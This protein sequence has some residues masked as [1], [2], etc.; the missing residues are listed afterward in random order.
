MLR[1]STLLQQSELGLRLVQAGPHDPEVSWATITELTDLGSYLDGGEIIMTTG[2]ALTSDDPRWRDFVS[3]LSRAQVAAIGFG[4]GVSHEHIPGPL[5]RAASDYRLALF[6]VP[7][8][9]PFIAVSKAV[10]GLLRADELRGAQAALRTQ[11]RILDSVGGE[12]DPSEVLASIA[13]VTGRQLQLAEATNVIASTAG[14]AAA[15]QHGPLDTVPLDAEGT[16]MLAIAAGPP[17]T[18]EGRSV[19]TAGAM[20]LSLSLRSAS[21]EPGRE[22]ERWE[23]VASRVLEGHLPW[24]AVTVLDPALRVPD[25]VRALLVQGAAESMS[26]WRHRAAIGSARLITIDGTAPGVGLVRGWQLTPNEPHLIEDAVG[27]ATSNGLDVVAGRAVAAAQV[28]LSARSARTRAARLSLTAPLYQVPRVPEVLW[29]D[30]DAPILEELLSS[31]RAADL[32]A[33]VL[34]PLSLHSETLG[35]ADRTMLRA[36]LETLFRADGQR[37]PAA[38]RLGIHRN[39]LR[40]RLSR[41][42]RLTGRTIG[43]PDDHAELWLALR[44]EDGT[45]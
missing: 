39:T 18:P 30:R 7:L 34:G 1:L 2:V 15:A 10:A 41:I 37:G 23:W 16:L 28:Q 6:E 4:V 24:G 3:S 40:D 33:A 8:P 31:E 35:V 14:F 43:A 26:V 27:I 22:R 32:C 20:V 29:A 25:Q 36:T 44:V 38:A 42:E 12:H 11:Q 21:F 19:V 17:L 45:G 13:Q 9:T 5:I